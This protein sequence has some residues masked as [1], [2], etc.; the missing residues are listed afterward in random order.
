VA[1]AGAAMWL[2]TVSLPAVALLAL[3]VPAYGDEP[4][5]MGMDSAD[6]ASSEAFATTLGASLMSDYLF[7]GISLSRHGPSASASIEV[8]H[9]GFYVGGEIDGV[10]LPG[11]PLAETTGAG[12]I[13]HEIGGVKFDVGVEGYYYP[14]ETPLP[15]SGATNYW[16]SNLSAS[17]RIMDAFE[18]IGKVAY[19][20][21][22]WNSGAW[23]M[24]GSGGLKLDLPKFQLAKEDISWMLV[25]ELGYQGYG[26][27]SVGAQLPDYAHWR[28]GVIFAHDKVNLE[29]NYQD[30]NLS[31]ESCFV[32]AGDASGLGGHKRFAE[33]TF[34][35]QSNL[36]G[37]T[38]VGTLSF[39][40][41]PPKP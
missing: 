22:V 32:L 3:L 17:R 4:I 11:D 15:G 30:T 38:L 2:G 28:L 41:E 29:L 8:E 19:S 33:N 35:L 25:G 40:F 21:S 23:G 18:V 26:T 20:P 12:G 16:Q 31:K 37:R 39:E 6:K 1:V 27:T 7:R 10:R 14:G 36:C 5:A 13:R 24:Y 9:N 34:G